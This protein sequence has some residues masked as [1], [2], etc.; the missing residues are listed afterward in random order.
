MKRLYRIIL[1]SYDSVDTALL[2]HDKEFHAD[3]LE[4]MVRECEPEALARN[5]A[6]F[7]AGWKEALLKDIAELELN[8]ERVREGK[9]PLSEGI[10]IQGLE[11]QGSRP[12]RLT[13]EYWEAQAEKARAS[14][15]DGWVEYATYDVMFDDLLQVLCER[16]EFE[17]V[18]V[19]ADV[20][21]SGSKTIA[22]VISRTNA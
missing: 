9:A 8:A 7:E 5:R 20:I 3:Q 10:E 15:A 22:D 12:R 14:L 19:T 2:Y 17:P 6:Q 1:T 21:R 4:E 11:I 13:P 16:F 18:G